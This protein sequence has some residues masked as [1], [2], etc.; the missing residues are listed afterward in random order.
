MLFQGYE[1][2]DADRGALPLHPSDVQQPALETMEAS[3]EAIGDR[4]DGKFQDVVLH[5]SL[6]TRLRRLP[7]WRNSFNMLQ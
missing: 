4:D 2:H 7:E 5:I 3:S 6:L 1:G